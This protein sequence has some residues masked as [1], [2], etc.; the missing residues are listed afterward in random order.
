VE[1]GNELRIRPRRCGEPDLTR[2]IGCKPIK[3]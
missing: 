3:F 2:E 1:R